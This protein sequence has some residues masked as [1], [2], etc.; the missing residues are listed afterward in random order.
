MLAEEIA[1]LTRSSVKLVQ[2]YLALYE[3]AQKVP[4]RLEKLEEELIRVN[5][6]HNGHFTAEKKG[7]VRL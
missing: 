4:H 3:A 6:G 5:G 1:F 2:D 7:Q